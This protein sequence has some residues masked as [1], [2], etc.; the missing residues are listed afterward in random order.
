MKK[1]LTLAAAAAI[2]SLGTSLSLAQVTI[3]LSPEVRTHFHEY[4]VKEKIEPVEVQTEIAV[5]AEV[6][7]EVTLHPVPDV[8]IERSPELAGHQYFVVGERIYVVGAEGRKVVTVI[9]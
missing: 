5:G 1:T 9:D 6:P 8:I 4:V 7:A 2:L 3:D